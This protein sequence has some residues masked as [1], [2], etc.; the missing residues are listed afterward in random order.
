M[1]ITAPAG[2]VDPQTGI[3]ITE[4]RLTPMRV[5]GGIWRTPDADVRDEL[6]R[7]P[8]SV[9][10][11]DGSVLELPEGWGVA[12]G[13]RS[14]YTYIYCYTIECEFGSLIDPTSVVAI[15]VNGTDIP[16]S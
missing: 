7:L 11:A 14:A 16:T 10:L 4:V 1:T 15:T 12:G 5:G 9:T 6:S 13:V 3:A 8:V 2:A